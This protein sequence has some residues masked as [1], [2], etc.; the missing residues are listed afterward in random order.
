M[1]LRKRLPS[2]TALVAL[3]ASIRHRSF[4]AAAREL[5]V[6]QAAVSRQIASLEENIGRPLFDRRHRSIEPTPACLILGSTL[7]ESFANIADSVEAVRASSTDVVTIGATIAFSSFWLLPKIAELRELNPSIQIR[8][9][10][11]DA[12]LDLESGGMD[13]G[14]RYGIP[15]FNDGTVI[16][17]CGDRIFPV[18][19]PEYASTHDLMTF[20]DGEYELIETDVPNRSW[21]RWADW[22]ARVG[23]KAGAARSTLRLSH[24]TETISAARSGQ[25][26]ALGWDTLIATFLSDGSLVKVGDIELEA[27]GRHNIL[28]PLNAKRSANSD[29]T[30]AWL[31][32]ALQR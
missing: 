28:V 12:K 29:L 8:V 14:V 2:L 20:P 11:Q 31:T 26:V 15:P 9:V 27:E 3:E 19:S 32:Q 17:S 13:I 6:T 4:T 23:R 24:Y 18:C 1:H 21:Y 16:A 25:G 7:A 10:S 5:G 22:F 30:A